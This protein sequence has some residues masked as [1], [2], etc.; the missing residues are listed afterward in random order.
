MMSLSVGAADHGRRSAFAAAVGAMA[1]VVTGAYFFAFDHPWTLRLDNKRVLF[2]MTLEAYRGWMRGEVPGWSD[3]FW[4]GYPLLAYPSAGGLYLPHLLPFWLTSPPHL[5]A[6][7]LATALHAGVLAAG[8]TYFLGLLGASRA[9]ALLGATLAV[10]APSLHWCASYWFTVYGAIAWWPWLLAA[11]ERLTSIARPGAGAWAL[12]WVALAAQVYVG[13]AEFALYSGVVAGL[14]VLTR[15]TGLAVRIRAWRVVLLAGGGLALALPQV[16]PTAVFVPDTPFAEP[17]SAAGLASLLLRSGWTVVLPGGPWDEVLPAFLGFA[18][19]VLTGVATWSRRPGAIFL[20]MLAA[21]SF[22]LALGPQTPAYGAFHAVPPFDRFRSPYKFIHFA[23]LATAWAAALGVEHLRRS[24]TWRRG[25]ALALALA[26]VGEHAAYA[27]RWLPRYQHSHPGDASAEEILGTLAASGLDAPPPPRSPPPRVHEAIGTLFMQ[28]SGNLSGVYPI[29]R[30]GGGEEMPLVSRRHVALVRFGSPGRKELD[31]FGVEL[32]LAERAAC[33]DLEA[34]LGLQRLSEKR[35]TCLLAN[36]SRPPRYEVV[37]SVRG[38]ETIEQMIRAV[39]A[40][41]A[42]PIPVVSPQA[43]SW[44][45]SGDTEGHVEVVSYRAGLVRLT[46]ETSAAAFLLVRESWVQG[47]QAHVDGRDAPIYPAAGLFFGTPLTP[48]RHQITLRY[49][50]PGLGL[51]VLV[52]A[53]WALG[54]LLRYRLT[55]RGSDV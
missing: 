27:A 4:S 55:S 11:A 7:D 37:S 17:P 21:V 34:R 31:L 51:G 44:T 42:A 53:A 18:A 35:T 38:V 52:A 54:A 25:A 48:G 12:G 9:P 24:G 50:T 41:A 20:A 47:W 3:R 14:W 39:R 22:V 23:E 49:R 6:Y 36:P 46:V 26:T 5:R 29:S 8:S 1:M 15:R 33:R 45:G 19:L 43:K 2:P 28:F 30:L 40:D 13:F 32:V 10:L 16:L